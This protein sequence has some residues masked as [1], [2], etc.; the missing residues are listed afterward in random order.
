[1]SETPDKHP[2]ELLKYGSEPFANYVDDNGDVMPISDM[3][4]EELDESLV[5][6]GEQQIDMFVIPTLKSKTARKLG[7]KAYGRP[8]V[9][10]EGV[11]LNVDTH[12]GA[13]TPED[14]ETMRRNG[15]E[16]E[17]KV[18]IDLDGK[19]QTAI[20]LGDTATAARITMQM[21]KRRQRRE[22]LGYG[23]VDITPDN[24]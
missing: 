12:S 22:E 7:R 16:M 17:R 15:D 13:Q 3:A 14:K 10:E 19:R 11:L 4:S 18:M 21:E 23:Q 6:Y 20:E 8:A 9:G 5:E 1:M 2:K 24:E